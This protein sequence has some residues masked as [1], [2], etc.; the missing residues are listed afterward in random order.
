[1]SFV[2]SLVAPVLAAVM[3]IAVAHCNSGCKAVEGP[4]PYNEDLKACVNKAKSLEESRLCREKV[5]CKYGVCSDFPELCRP[6]Q[7]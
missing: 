3:A 1:M 7:C 6:N 5:D 2:K 4:D